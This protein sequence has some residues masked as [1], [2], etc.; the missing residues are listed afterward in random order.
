VGRIP[1][2]NHFLIQLGKNKKQKNSTYPKECTEKHFKN[3]NIKVWVGYWDLDSTIFNM[4]L[5]LDML[6]LP[7]IIDVATSTRQKIVS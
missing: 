6:K 3:I 5:F 1:H 7:H 4:L 2:C